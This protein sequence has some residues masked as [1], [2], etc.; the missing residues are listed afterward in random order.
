M[1]RQIKL[2]LQTQIYD[3]TRCEAS[4]FFGENNKLHPFRKSTCYKPDLECGSLE[5]YIDEAKLEISSMTI[6]QYQDNLTSE[7]R[8]ALASLKYNCH[9]VIKKADKSDTGVIMDR[10]KCI[11]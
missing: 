5:N 3:Q 10:E 6:K 7:E 4:R 2:S 8:A 9:I 11:I 1:N